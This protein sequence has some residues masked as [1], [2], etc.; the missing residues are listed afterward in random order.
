M[1]AFFCFTTAVIIAIDVRPKS[2]FVSNMI[3][4][5]LAATS[6]GLL[7]FILWTVSVLSSVKAGL[8]HG[9]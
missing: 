1:S 6:G 9:T 2:S 4:G 3:Y 8:T 5:F 7:L